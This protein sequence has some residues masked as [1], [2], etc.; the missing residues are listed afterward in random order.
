MA[1]RHAFRKHFQVTRGFVVS[2]SSYVWYTPSGQIGWYDRF[3]VSMQEF[4]SSAA[5]RSR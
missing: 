1:V 4:A 2:Q 3:M 5:C